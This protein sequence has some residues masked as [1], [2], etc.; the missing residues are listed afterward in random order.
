MQFLRKIFG[1]KSGS[2]AV[3]R[4][5]DRTY[6]SP[7]VKTGEWSIIVDKNGDEVIDRPPGNNDFLMRPS[8]EYDF[9]GTI[10]KFDPTQYATEQ[11]RFGAATE[12]AMRAHKNEAL[13]KK[14]MFLLSRR[15]ERRRRGRH[16][17]LR[18]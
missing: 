7:P 12:H 2:M 8:V 17:R 10:P 11:E 9:R 16:V 14:A 4:P 3:E 5:Q 6:D 13:L 1:P 15:N 18:Q